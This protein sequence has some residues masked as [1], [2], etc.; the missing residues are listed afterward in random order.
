MRDMIRVHIDYD[1]LAQ[2]YDRDRLDEMVSLMVEVLC[3]C[4]PTFTISGKVLPSELVKERMCSLNSCHIEY[5]IKSMNETGRDIHNIKQY[6]LAVLFNAPASMNNHYDAM[7]RR[8]RWEPVSKAE[9][10]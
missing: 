4:S 8:D 6:L 10:L 7:I 3:S 1:A 5:A 9:V 2:E